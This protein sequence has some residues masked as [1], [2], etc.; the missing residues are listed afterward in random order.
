M[1]DLEKLAAIDVAKE[2]EEKG[3]EIEINQGNVQL[4]E[5]NPTANQSN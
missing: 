2:C 4:K 5:N 1:I 3:L